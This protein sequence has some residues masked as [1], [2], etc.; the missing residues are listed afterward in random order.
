ML[1]ENLLTGQVIRIGAYGD[2]YLDG[3]KITLCD[4]FNP[5][6]KTYEA[7]SVVLN[8]NWVKKMGA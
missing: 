3:I 1:Y 6:N 4:I 8:E 2:S 7:G 5:K